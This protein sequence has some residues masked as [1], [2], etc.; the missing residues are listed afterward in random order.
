MEGSF[1]ARDYSYRSSANAYM[2]V[3]VQQKM[4][5]DVQ[6]LAQTQA[7]T[8][9]ATD[10][11]H[12]NGSQ[13]T[14]SAA[15]AAGS[16]NGSGGGGSTKPAKQRFHLAEYHRQLKASR[17][18]P[19]QIVVPPALTQRFSE[20]DAERERERKAKDEEHLYMPVAVLSEPTLRKHDIAMEFIMARNI[21]PLPEDKEPTPLTPLDIPRPLPA[22]RALRPIAYQTPTQD[23]KQLKKTESF[24][25]FLPIMQKM[26]HVA[27]HHQQ[28]F[29]MTRRKTEKI[30]PS[31]FIPPSRYHE[32]TEQVVRAAPDNAQVRVGLYFRDASTDFLIP[33][34]EFVSLTDKSAVMIIFKCK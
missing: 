24:G 6:A 4:L 27:P 31:H 17:P 3:Y 16:S 26:Q 5:D 19:I 21:N 32:S 14:D 7:Q 12:T 20:L 23:F 30:R 11:K 25:G 1:G 29:E 28:F 15:A 18:Q 8:A 22:P 9:A 13:M 33:H 2:L 34:R 10:S